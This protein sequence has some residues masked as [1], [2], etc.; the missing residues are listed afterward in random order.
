MGIDK[1]MRLDYNKKETIVGGRN[2]YN[3]MEAKTHL[4]LD[5]KIHCT[6]SKH[7]LEI[8]K[9]D[10]EI[11]GIDSMSSFVNLI[12]RSYCREY[13]KTVYERDR[14]LQA[15]LD[16]EEDAD[17]VPKRLE[18]DSI[19]KINVL[20]NSDMREIRKNRRK[21][22]TGDIHVTPGSGNTAELYLL[23][24]TFQ[25]RN[26]DVITGY[27]L[28]QDAL[29]SMFESYASLP[30]HKRE[31]ILYNNVY[32]TIKELV[33]DGNKYTMTFY[34]PQSDNPVIERIKVYDIVPNRERMHNYVIGVTEESGRFFCCRLDRIYNAVVN[35]DVLSRDFTEDE[36]KCLQYMSS[37]CPEFAYDENGMQ[38][39][40]VRFTD[41]GLNL[42]YNSINTHKPA[43]FTV[44][45][46]DSHILHFICP[47]FQ[48]FIYLRKFGADAVVLKPV[49]LRNQMKEYYTK[50]LDA[51]N[52]E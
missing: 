40:E 42:F 19:Y 5:N 48:L 33:V 12:I 18:R 51:Y 50:A 41:D 6:V 30:L 34:I 23:M 22:E 1:D 45:E 49:E 26:G 9:S 38:D 15:I 4:G 46:N 7:T 25:K 17:Y 28:M 11:F 20:F 32:R 21:G 14:K 39:V 3:R 2:G 43:E 29:N 36:M 8:I 37:D 16:G 52:K 24:S 44:D 10:K 47:T 35:N 27:D 13:I 31:I